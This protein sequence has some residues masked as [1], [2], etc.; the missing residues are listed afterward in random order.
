VFYKILYRQTSLPGVHFEGSHKGNVRAEASVDTSARQA[1][2]DSIIG[3]NPVSDMTT[4][5]FNYVFER[6]RYHTRSKNG[7]EHQETAR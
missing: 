4:L 2:E 5:E 1:Q 3:R 7:F 6:I